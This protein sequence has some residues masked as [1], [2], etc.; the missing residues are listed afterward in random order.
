MSEKQ[1]ATVAQEIQEINLE[2]LCSVCQVTPDF[3]MELI[4][5][6]TI[7]LKDDKTHIFD[8]HQIH[9]VHTAVR[10]HDDLEVNHAG[11]ALAI[12][13]L[14]EMDELRKHVEMLEKYLAGTSKISL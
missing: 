5:Y 8:T 11:I 1:G 10:L 13:L 4:A 14:K 9:I 7:E 6:G 12:D 2:E 3:V